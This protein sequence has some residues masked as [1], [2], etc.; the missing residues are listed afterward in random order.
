MIYE[1]TRHATE[2]EAIAQ[3][4]AFKLAWCFGYGPSYQVYKDNITGDWVCYTTRYSSCD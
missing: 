4:E 3:G 2:L 1:T